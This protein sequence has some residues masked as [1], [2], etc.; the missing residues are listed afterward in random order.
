MDDFTAIFPGDNEESDALIKFALPFIYVVHILNTRLFFFAAGRV[1]CV[2][3]ETRKVAA[4]HGQR[5]YRSII[6]II[7]ESGIIYPIALVTLLFVHRNAVIFSLVQIV[8]IAPTLIIVQVGLGNAFHDVQSCIT[9]M[10]VASGLRAEIGSVTTR[11]PS[12]IV[13]EMGRTEEVDTSVGMDGMD[14]MIGKPDNA[15]LSP[16]E[17]FRTSLVAFV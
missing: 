10:R 5:I 14:G 17:Q 9:T 7:V 6:A 4:F 12:G 2:V 11:P 3:R 1:F 15:H 13:I 8:G 16:K